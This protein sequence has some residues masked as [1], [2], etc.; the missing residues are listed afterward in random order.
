MASSTK[1]ANK[2][3]K[4]TDPVPEPEHLP[5]CCKVAGRCHCFP[6]STPPE[7]MELEE[8]PPL[9]KISLEEDAVGCLVFLRSALFEM[10]IGPKHDLLVPVNDVLKRAGL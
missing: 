8:S 7:P 5:I 1:A 3:A 4:S 9:R 6:E 10:G 2:P